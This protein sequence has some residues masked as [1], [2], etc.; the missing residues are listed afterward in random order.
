MMKAK[1]IGNNNDAVTVGKVYDV[2]LNHTLFQFTDDNGEDHYASQQL[3][4]LLPDAPK[5]EWMQLNESTFLNIITGTSIEFETV[6]TEMPLPSNK[7]CAHIYI[8]GSLK[9]EWIAWR[10]HAD[11]FAALV[12]YKWS[13]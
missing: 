10:N 5:S 1:W 2:T 7:H 8:N 4:E 3:F 9:R 12:N 6:V 11:A 13:A